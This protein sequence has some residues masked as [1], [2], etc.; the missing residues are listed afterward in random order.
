[1]VFNENNPTNNAFEI[2][3]YGVIPSRIIEELKTTSDW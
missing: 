3:E 2:F 1:M